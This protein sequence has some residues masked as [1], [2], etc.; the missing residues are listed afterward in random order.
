MERDFSF[1]LVLVPGAEMDFSLK[2]SFESLVCKGIFSSVNFRCRLSYG[3]CTAPMCNG[4]HKHAR[5]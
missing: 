2:H 4:I 5:T 1:R 3:V